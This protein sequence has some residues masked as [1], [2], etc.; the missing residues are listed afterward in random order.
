MNLLHSIKW[1]E[2]SS[3][4]QSE[5]DYVELWIV[6]FDC[7]KQRQSCNIEIN[8]WKQHQSCKI[9][10]W[11]LENKVV[12]TICLYIRHRVNGYGDLCPQFGNPVVTERREKIAVHK[13]I[14]TQG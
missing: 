11:K 10:S 5:V 13:S 12:C 2:T 9:E 8:S 7:W 14:L 1:N 6:E 3:F 4:S